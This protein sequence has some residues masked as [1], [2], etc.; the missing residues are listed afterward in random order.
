MAAKG[1][2]NKGI[3]RELS[4]SVPIVKSHRANIDNKPGVALR[5]EAVLHGLERGSFGLGARLEHTPPRAHRG[6]KE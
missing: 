5:T 3:A 4:L 6:R 1:H 2:D